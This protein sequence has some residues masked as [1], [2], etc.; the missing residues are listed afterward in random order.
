PCGLLYPNGIRYLLLK[1][2]I[3]K[4]GAVLIPLNTRYRS[5][6]LSFMLRFSDTRFLFMVDRFFLKKSTLTRGGPIYDDLAVFH[7]RDRE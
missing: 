1:F 5:S 7:L 6:E 3:L 4:V 2:A